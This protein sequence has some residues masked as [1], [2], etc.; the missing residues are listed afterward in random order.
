MKETLEPESR[1]VGFLELG[2]EEVLELLTGGLVG[3]GLGMSVEE[4]LKPST[5]LNFR[6]MIP[7]IVWFSAD[8]N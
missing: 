1:L 3:G 8:R 5:H 6:K 2:A 4:E 7:P